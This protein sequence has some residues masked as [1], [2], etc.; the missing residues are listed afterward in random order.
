M[1]TPKV[2]I[3]LELKGG[4]FD[5]PKIESPEMTQLDPVLSFAKAP[6]SAANDRPTEEISLNYTK[7]EFEYKPQ[8][9]NVDAFF[10]YGLD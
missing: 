1:L 9:D 6:S 2:E 8:A 7:I 5:Y 4:S 10:A 3:E